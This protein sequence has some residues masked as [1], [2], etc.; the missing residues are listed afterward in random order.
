M[1]NTVNVP[2]QLQPAVCLDRH[3]AGHFPS[4]TQSC[5]R[6]ASPRD[7]TPPPCLPPSQR[8]GRERLSSS[9]A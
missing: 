7:P 9:P 6:V 4:S 1:G 8:C 2:N 5:G 3:T